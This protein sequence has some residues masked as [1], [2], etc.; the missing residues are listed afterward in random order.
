M[1]SHCPLGGDDKEKTQPRSPEEGA[2]IFH[3]YFIFSDSCNIHAEGFG[4]S[5]PMPRGTMQ[6]QKTHQS[7]WVS[8]G[9]SPHVLK[10]HEKQNETVCMLARVIL[11]HDI[12]LI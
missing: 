2:F 9:S 7:F 5:L 12:W 4:F 3:F 8:N 11:G 1:A 6:T 10:D